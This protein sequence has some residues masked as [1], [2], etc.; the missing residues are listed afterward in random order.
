MW[1]HIPLLVVLV[2]GDLISGEANSGTFRLL[3]SRP[4][5]RTK[6]INAKFIAALVYTGALVIFIGLISLPIGLLIFG[7]GD[8]MVFLGV[9]NVIP[10]SEL[11]LR[12]AMAFGFGLLSMSTVACLSL[13]LSSMARNSL[14][15]ILSTIAII[16]LLTLISSIN[17]KVFNIIRPVL[18]T[19]YLNSW[20]YLFSYEIDIL[21]LLRDGLILLAHMLV[22]Y[23][24]TRIYFNR[25]DILT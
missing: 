9:L 20:Q 21:L 11:P 6:L 15:P 8:L 14:G 19:S 25:K 10:E 2:T 4:V 23:L 13:M 12:F 16:I 17:L 1:V 3:L 24:V 5:S 7:K 18:F 22:F